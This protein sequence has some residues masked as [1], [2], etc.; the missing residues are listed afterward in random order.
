ME[1]RLSY[2][3]HRDKSAAAAKRAAQ[4][5]ALLC[6][7]PSLSTRSRQRLCRILGESV[8]WRLLLELASFQGVIPLVSHNLA[9][10]GL[11]DRV[12]QPYLNQLQREYNRT[13][14]RNVTLSDDLAKVLS[15]FTQHNIQAICLKGTVLAEVLY[16][17]PALRPI[18]DRRP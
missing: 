16:D 7:T 2:R 4:E 8:D 3:G 6:T 9:V 14:Y 10:S 15:A 12:P 13:V 5:V 18:T 17:N 1:Q 11:S